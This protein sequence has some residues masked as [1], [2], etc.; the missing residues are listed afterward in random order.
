M[1][2]PSSLEKT[3]FIFTSTY[4][5]VEFNLLFSDVKVSTRI[6]VTNLQEFSWGCGLLREIAAVAPQKKAEKSEVETLVQKLGRLFSR[7]FPR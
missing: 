7:S 6:I 5:T 2:F 3:R 4:F 1:H